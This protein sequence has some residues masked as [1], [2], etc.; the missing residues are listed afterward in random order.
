MQSQLLAGGIKKKPPISKGKHAC[1]YPGCN[2][3][4]H[5]PGALQNHVD[6]HNGNFKNVCDYVDE[7]GVKCTYKCDQAGNMNKHKATHNVEDQHK[8]EHAGCNRSFVKLYRL[9]EHIDFEHL[10][11]YKNCEAKFEHAGDLNRHKD[12]KHND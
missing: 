3:K 10:K 4:F 8:S 11:E 5:R 1:T 2:R 12:S 7:N 6:F 9:R